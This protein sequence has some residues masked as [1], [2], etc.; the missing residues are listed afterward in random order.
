MKLKTLGAAL[1][2]ASVPLLADNP[3]DIDSFAKAKEAVA[4]AKEAGTDHPSDEA[5]AI[6]DALTALRM[7]P[8]STKYKGHRGEALEALNAALGVAG[9][10][11]MTAGNP[12]PSGTSDSPGKMDDLLDVAQ[13]EIDLAFAA[14]NGDADAP[15]VSASAGA[16]GDA[17]T[18]APPTEAEQKA[19]RSVVII[20]GDNSQGTGFLVK[21]ADG[22]CVITN[23]HVLFDNPNAKIT[24]PGGDTV[25]TTGLKGASDRDMAIIGIEDKG[26]AYLDFSAD[27][28][29]EAQ[30]GDDLMTP[31]NS[32]GGEVILPTRGKLLATGT[33]RIEFDN[34]IYHG[35]SG[36]PVFDVKIGKVL[37]VVTQAEKVNTSNDLDKAS[38]NSKNSAI[39]RSMRY[40][41]FRIDTVPKWEPYDWPQF[42]AESKQIDD[43]RT[44]SIALWSYLNHLDTIGSKTPP[45][46]SLDTTSYLEDERLR[47]A[48]LDWQSALDRNPPGSSNRARAT[49]QLLTTL[50]NLADEQVEV[51]GNTRFLTYNAQ[52]AKDEIDF[53]KALKDE[54]DHIDDVIRR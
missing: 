7:L 46:K 26:Y 54:L 2:F 30:I 23:L 11:I 45:A 17:K 14:W 47:S 36:G 50:R 25:A 42:L 9:R 3:G 8:P 29:K 52:S 41:G 34:P 37:G 31:G 22:P 53:R 40:F 12:N 15:A 27:V 13:Q 48:D 28:A 38:F 6:R 1:L 43:F 19:L 5:A 16:K 51:L 10:L 32:K 24:T 18:A 44:R 33:Q 39:T 4:K 49:E 20:K 21:T 35:N